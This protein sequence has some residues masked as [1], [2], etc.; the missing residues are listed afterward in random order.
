M[1][2]VLPAL[3]LGSL[4]VV[5]PAFAKNP[6][7][8]GVRKD[9][10]IHAQIQP[11][12]SPGA[13]WRNHGEFI[14]CF[15]REHLGGAITSDAARSDIG[16]HEDESSEEAEPSPSSS[17]TASPN[18]SISPSPTSSESASPSASVNISESTN[19]ELKA[20]IAVLQNIL[21]SLQALRLS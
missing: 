5:S 7:N 16:K 4:L 20:F 3:I 10:S 9:S 14:S 11:S 15:A 2:K 6:D 18:P 21:K 19:I 17:P 8:D 13:T 12:C 1:N